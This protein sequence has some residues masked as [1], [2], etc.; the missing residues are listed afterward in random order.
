MRKF[1]ALGLAVALLSIGVADAALAKKKK[2]K[3]YHWNRYDVTMTCDVANTRV[4]VHNPSKH[5]LS[6]VVRLTDAMGDTQQVQTIPAEGLVN[7][8]CASTGVAATAV[9]SFEGPGSLHA[10]ATYISPG[11]QLDVV[12]VR[13]VAASG[14]K[15]PHDDSDTGDSDSASGD[16]TGY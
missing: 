15:P 7:F 16:P 1:L 11:G 10:T 8:D 13:P 6:V 4:L 2:K 3:S 9:L 12:Q 14:S 5:D